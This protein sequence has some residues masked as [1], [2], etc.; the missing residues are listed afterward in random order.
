MLECTVVME[1]CEK[2]TE[3]WVVQYKILVYRDQLVREHVVLIVVVVRAAYA[4]GAWW[5]PWS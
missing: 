1:N 4:A 5:P 3:I 2:I